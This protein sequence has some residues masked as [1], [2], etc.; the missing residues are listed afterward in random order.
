MF[1]DGHEACVDVLGLKSRALPTNF[2]AADTAQRNQQLI[3]R[4]LASQSGVV[5]QKLF[6][7]MQVQILSRATKRAVQ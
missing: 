4:M 1:R 3:T 6:G 2:G 5:N 7:D